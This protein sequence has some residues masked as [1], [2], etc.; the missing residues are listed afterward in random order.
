MQDHPKRVSA[1]S[2]L[3]F[4]SVL[5]WHL[6]VARSATPHAAV[7]AGSVALLSGGLFYALS[8]LEVR[9]GALGP[10]WLGGLALPM[11]RFATMLGFLV[12][13]TVGLP[14]F[15]LFSGFIGMLLNPPVD[16]FIGMPGAL[17]VILL[18]WFAGSWYLFRMMQ[19]LLFG[20]HRSDILYEDLRPTEVAAFLIVLAVLI[21]L[22]LAPNGSFDASIFSDGYRTAMRGS[23]W[24]P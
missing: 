5:W 12:M 3:V 19:R 10:E 20:P 1:Y 15:G 24:N 21:G 7:Y 13:A 23:P 6:A 17:S 9:Y 16:P 22:G 8:R 4:Y 2:G 11:P 14:P 18:A